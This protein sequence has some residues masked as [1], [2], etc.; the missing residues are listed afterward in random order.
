VNN[1]KPFNTKLSLAAVLVLVLL[2]ATASPALA[3]TI[4]VDG[5]R[6][7]AWNGGGDAKRPE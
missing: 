3:I 1:M 7:S 4:T 6:E 5:S 2:V